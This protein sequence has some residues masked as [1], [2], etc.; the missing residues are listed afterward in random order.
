MTSDFIWNNRTF[1]ASLQQKVVRCSKCTES[2]SCNTDSHNNE[3]DERENE[4]QVDQYKKRK[5]NDINYRKE[6]KDLIQYLI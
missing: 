3:V 1:K 6:K 4:G 2:F 5:G